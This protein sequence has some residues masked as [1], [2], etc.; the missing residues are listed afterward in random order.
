MIVLLS[1]LIDICNHIL[2]D[3]ND[4]KIAIYKFKATHKL[5]ISDA[6]VI[7]TNPFSISDAG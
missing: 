6:P 4:L 2:A 1:L 5:I 7:I 3:L